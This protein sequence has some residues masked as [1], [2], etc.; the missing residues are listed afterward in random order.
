M[1]KR[2]IGAIVAAG[3]IAVAVGSA[4]TASNTIPDSKAGYGT[5]NISGATATSL[6]YTLAADGKTITGA[7]LVFNEDLT[8][9]TVK[10]AF[11]TDAL[12]TCVV[13][14]FATPN[15]PVSCTGFTQ[16]TATSATFNVSVNS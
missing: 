11:G 5:S 2:T 10:A 9:K 7:D 14:T 1:R 3:V 8:G 6:T 4:S 12:A 16:S 15:Q 13:G